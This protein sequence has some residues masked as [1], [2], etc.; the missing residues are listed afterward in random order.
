MIPTSRACIH[1][2]IAKY[3]HYSYYTMCVHGRKEEGAIK[4]TARGFSS[5]VEYAAGMRCI[6]V[7]YSGAAIMSQ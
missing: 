1:N 3:C 5:L 4:C 2:E 6:G 7:A